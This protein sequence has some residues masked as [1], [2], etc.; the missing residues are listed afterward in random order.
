MA[1]SLQYVVKLFPAS[2]NKVSFDALPRQNR[3]TTLSRFMVLAVLAPVFTWGIISSEAQAQAPTVSDTV[4][5][6]TNDSANDGNFATGEILYERATVTGI[7]TTPSG[8][9]YGFIRQGTTN[10]SLFTRPDAV[11]PNWVAAS[12]PYAGPSTLTGPWTFH[13]SS[14][15][16]F[17]TGTVTLATTP[18][19][20]SV[21]I[22]P[23]VSSMTITPG[24]SPLSPNISWVLPSTVGTD[25][26]GTPLPTISQVQISVSDNTSPINRFNINPFATTAVV[27]FGSSF[28]QANVTYSATPFSPSTT[29]FTIPSTNDNTN[30]ADFGSPVLQYGHTYSIAIQL[31]NTTAATPVPGCALCTVDS[32]SASFF[33]YTP[34]N[35]AS[36]GLPANTVINLPST[37]P[38]P[39]TSGAF[40][41]PVYHF[42]V[43]N[44]G[45]SS[46][47]TY[48]DPAAAF[49]YVYTIGLGNPNFASVD[50]LTHVGTG[51]YQL[52]VW[53]G[54]SYVLA[55]SALAAN[56]VFNF[57]TNGFVS[58]VSQF[59]IIGI[60]PGVDPTDITAFVTGLTFTSDGAFTGTMQ[61]L[62]QVTA[63]PLPAAISLFATGLGSLGLLGWFRKRKAA[64]AMAVA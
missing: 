18:A 37:T 36:L 23:F 12:I 38:I 47:T 61:P 49:G 62:V 63:T 28:S 45:P 52:L 41:G 24:S 42:N 19:V 33:D 22:M 2:S 58:G 32:R 8:P 17:T 50:A 10:E 3:T 29:N 55:D 9:P 21:G 4:S 46:G 60:D 1:L 39:T 7:T 20:G 16:G 43:S 30:N 31:D 5:V 13:V 56:S 57:L 15:T 25:L 44:V 40:A 53:N 51:I 14:T 35:P 11:N 6:L 48:I 59:E 54:T 64:T 26:F 34:I 27:P